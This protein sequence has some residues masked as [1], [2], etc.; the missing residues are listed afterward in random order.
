MEWAA[1]SRLTF[2]GA[3]NRK[4]QRGAD[5]WGGGG[6]VTTGGEAVQ[7]LLLP[8]EGVSVHDFR[9]CAIYTVFVVR[10]EESVVFNR[11]VFLKCVM[12]NTYSS[13]GEKWLLV[14]CENEIIEC[15]CVRA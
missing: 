13:C 6:G 9:A 8:N 12:I 15:M 1:E 2:R 4:R 3:R 10:F 14:T 5:R 11:S 7:C